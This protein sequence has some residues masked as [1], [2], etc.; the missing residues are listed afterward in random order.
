MSATREP[1]PEDY[2]VLLAQL[3]EAIG[4]ARLKA[5]LSVNRELTLL[6]W[7]IGRDILSRQSAGGWGSKVI[8]RLA[9]DLVVAFP[10]MK[11]LS[12]R[13]LN[14]MRAFAEAWPDPEIVQQLVAQ[15]PFAK[16]AFR[17]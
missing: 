1:V 15:L 10:G 6:Y 11:G 17:S 4:H 3:K 2:A 8:H 16:R 13:N 12:A 9:A 14:Y 5:A 7:Q